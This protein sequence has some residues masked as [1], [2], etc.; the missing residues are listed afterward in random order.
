MSGIRKWFKDNELGITIAAYGVGAM[1]IGGTVGYVL[2]YNEHADIC[3]KYLPDLL[4]EFMRKGGGAADA[5]ICEK[6]PGAEQLLDAYS[7]LHPHEL[8]DLFA[9]IVEHD[10]AEE[11]VKAGLG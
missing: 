9:E 10:V 4:K 1:I 3:R 6:V 8:S 11:L 7:A 5:I 2:G